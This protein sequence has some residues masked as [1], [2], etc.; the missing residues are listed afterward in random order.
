MLKSI[1]ISNFR[2]FRQ[3]EVTRLA[4][5]NLVVGKN[6]SGKSAFLEAIEL[7][8]SN[9]SPYVILDL[10]KS[11]QETWTSESQLLPRNSLENSVRHLF[12]GHRLPDLGQEGIRIGETKTRNQIHLTTAAFIREKQPDGTISLVRVST[13]ESGADPS[14]IY[15]ALVAEDGERTRRIL[16]LEENIEDIRRPYGPKRLAADFKYPWQVVPTENMSNRKVATLWDLTSLTDQES[17]VIAA[18]RLIIE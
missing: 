13:I 12:F 4:R 16:S 18:L 8:A 15:F 1:N 6:N 7:F 10:V 11:R 2:L 14:D 17:E 9:A 3:I 5:I